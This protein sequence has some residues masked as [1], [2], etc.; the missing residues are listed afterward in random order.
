MSKPI[1][2]KSPS[3]AD[4]DA[5]LARLAAADGVVLSTRERITALEAR[6][7]EL[8][9]AAG[10]L[11]TERGRAYASGELDQ[12]VN[13]GKQY[14]AN[15]AE[16]GDAVAAVKAMHA[17]TDD[18]MIAVL[19]AED[20][21]ERLHGAVMHA[22]AA[23]ERAALVAYLKPALS[24]AWRAHY[25]AG[26]SIS[27]GSW[28]HDLTDELDGG[29]EAV[30]AADVKLPIQELCPRSGLIPGNPRNGDQRRAD[31]N[32]LREKKRA[33]SG[34]DLAQAA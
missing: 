6:I 11:E 22:F 19:D 2:P 26:N 34:A 10:H 20:E 24:R 16:H 9:V 13:L 30:F 33:A 29:H 3:V 4:F 14:A 7:A 32:A 31:L 25:A 15:R 12:A 8:D 18:L 27:F 1:T 5:A 21:A 28:C 23:Q 17:S